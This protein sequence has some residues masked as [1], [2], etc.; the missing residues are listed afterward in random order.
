[1]R[2]LTEL[3]QQVLLI[4]GSNRAVPNRLSLITSTWLTQDCWSRWNLADLRSVLCTLHAMV[5]GLVAEVAKCL[6]GRV[7]VVHL[8]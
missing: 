4:G 7:A 8:A 1:M 2:T 6:S 3:N 5:M